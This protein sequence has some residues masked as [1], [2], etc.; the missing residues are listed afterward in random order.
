MERLI[1]ES[2]KNELLENRVQLNA[3]F[4]A[5][6]ALSAGIDTES[7]NRLFFSYLGL[8]LQPGNSTA[9]GAA[10]E[11]FRT[12][13]DIVSSGFPA[14]GGSGSTGALLYDLAGKFSYLLTD[15][16][17]MFLKSTSAALSVFKNNDSAARWTSLVSMSVEFRPS[18][19]DY[20][21]TGLVCAWLA[22]MT[23]FR[24]KG[25]ELARTL[26][27]SLTA[28]L[29]G[30]KSPL[31]KTSA[32][33]LID[34]MKSDP[35]IK[36]IS[37]HENGLFIE[38]RFTW[39]GGFDGYGGS[40]AELPQV[41]TDGNDIFIISGDRCFL[42]CAD[43]F[44]ADIIPCD[45]IDSRVSS[46]SND[47]FFNGTDISFG[48]KRFTLPD[49]MRCVP[50]SYAAAGNTSAWTTAASYRVFIAGFPRGAE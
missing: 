37:V 25:L 9:H 42:L 11:L 23:R 24:E 35:W 5:A 28:A 38:P 45:N 2:L 34:E 1:P 4:R 21:N 10:S 16:P 7:F 19:E 50:S 29:F 12:L 48:E 30:L 47:N 14:G 32:D 43:I 13:L 27:P 3:L 31:S 18:F 8:M 20:K 44:G 22:G 15:H 46:A 40:F 39:C 33:S 26:D 36:P 6:K 17:G 49:R 41:G